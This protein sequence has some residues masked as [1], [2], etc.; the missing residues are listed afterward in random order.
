[1]TQENSQQSPTADPIDSPSQFDQN[2][3]GFGDFGIAP[4][5]QSSDIKES[6]DKDIKANVNEDDFGDFGDFGIASAPTAG[7]SDTFAQAANDDDDDF[8]DFGAAPADGEASFPS[9]D[10]DGF[11]D[12]GD[13]SNGADFGADAGDFG[14]FEGASASDAFAGADAQ[15]EFGTTSTESTTLTSSAPE[16]TLP[17]STPSALQESAVETAP[18]FNAMI[19][20]QVETYVLQK[21]SALYPLSDDA[22]NEELKDDS[23]QEPP[24]ALLNPDL[25]QLLDVAT[26]LSDQELWTSLCEQS[27]QGT[28]QANGNNTGVNDNE[29]PSG[30]NKEGSSSAPQFQWKYSTLRREYYASLGLVLT[31]EQTTMPAATVS[32]TAQSPSRAKT[33]SPAAIGSSDTIAERKPLDVEATRTYCQFTKENLGG[34]SGDEM[35]EIIT[36][37]TELTKQASDELTYWLDQREQLMMDSERYNEMIASLV[38]RAA[39]LKDAES[40][41]ATKSKRLTRSSF[42]LK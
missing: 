39:Q 20:R 36:R 25:D 38:G 35:K 30:N 4:A 16:T 28:N 8:G 2:D 14:D 5:A 22:S 19:S 17:E 37:L 32:S 11:G 6:S 21:L 3:D 15:D 27:F 42:N 40:K 24:S 13:F 18:D 33:S 9:G 12:F 34:Y 26:V 7:S 1:M 23:V 31:K 29:L 10:D 41:L